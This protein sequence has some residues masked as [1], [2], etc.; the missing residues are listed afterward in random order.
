MLSNSVPQ[1]PRKAMNSTKS[2]SP[3][4][5]ISIAAHIASTSLSL[6]SPTLPLLRNVFSSSFEIVPPL[7]L[8]IWSNSFLSCSGLT[9]PAESEMVIL[10]AMPRMKC[11]LYLFF[12][13]S[14]ALR[15]K[16]NATLLKRSTPRM[17]NKAMTPPFICASGSTYG[18]GVQLTSDIT[19]PHQSSS[20]GKVPSY[21][22]TSSE[23]MG[24]WIGWGT[25]NA[26]LYSSIPAKNS[27]SLIRTIV[28]VLALTILCM[29]IVV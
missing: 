22:A 5:S 15:W 28:A 29:G 4:L 27:S 8:S 18:L 25:W 13:V 16:N 6:I 14:M 1:L 7:S 24:A 19:P 11:S 17:T 12:C 20:A 9:R 26:S 3:E 10:R 21:F 2:T 23:V